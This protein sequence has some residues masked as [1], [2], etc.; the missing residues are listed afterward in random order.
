MSGAL[1]FGSY[2]EGTSVL[3]R[4]DARTKL[5][6]GLAFMVVTLL[7]RNLAGLAPCALLVAALYA[8][9]RIPAGKAIRSLAPT[10]GIVVLVSVLRLFT[11][12][13]GTTLF[14]LGVIRISEGSLDVAGFTA[15]RLALMMM[16]MSLVTM[17]TTTLDLACA[18]ERMLSPLARLGVPARE[19]GA[20]MGIALR[21]MP[22][23]AD[24]LQTI[25]RAQVSRGA[26][27]KASPARGARMFLSIAVPVFAGVFRHAETLATAMDARCYHG[28]EGRTRLHPMRLGTR[29][30]VAACVLVALVIATILI[31]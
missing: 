24:E 28:E 8:L 26:R 13:G 6:A 5:A 30:A 23:L 22:Q 25:R 1:S 21:F 2:V 18:L 17:T 31:Q 4:L 15:L 9:A 14:E 10:L 19:I 12:Q 3:H 16:A 11:Q 29:D 7:A 20:I 27:L